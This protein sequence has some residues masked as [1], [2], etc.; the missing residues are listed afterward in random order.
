M[1]DTAIRFGNWLNLLVAGSVFVMG[2]YYLFRSPLLKKKRFLKGVLVFWLG[3]WLVFVLSWSLIIFIYP[4]KNGYLL[5]ILSDLQSILAIG[6]SI[7]LLFG[8]EFK[9][10]WWTIVRSL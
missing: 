7:A 10:H 8:E 6:F 9:Q 2:L 5:L 4:G 1:E 3:Q